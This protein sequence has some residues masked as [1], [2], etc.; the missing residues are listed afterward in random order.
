MYCHKC[1]KQSPENFVNCAYCGAKLKPQKKKEP[2]KFQNKK[3][4]KI[5][6]SLKTLL[7]ILIIIASVLAVAAI[8]SSFFTS[9]KPERVVKDFVRSVDKYDKELYFS[10]YDESLIK[11]KKENRYFGDDETFN[12]MVIPVDDSVAFYTEKCGE[13]FN[14]KYEVKSSKTLQENELDSFNQMLESDF[15]YI[16]F[17]SQ[18]DILSVEIQATGDRG[19]Y[20]SIYNDFWC[21][22]IKGH[23]YMVDKTIY[24]QYENL[25]TTS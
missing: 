14:L 12:Q 19:E 1:H 6:I 23:W 22:K 7:K 8:I 16:V 15:N 24:T 21:M 18:V 20:K 2:S 4:I 17:P 13:E 9:S 11:Y 10:L 5:D 25:Q 3:K